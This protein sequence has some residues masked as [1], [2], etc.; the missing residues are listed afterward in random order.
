MIASIE[1]DNNVS[2]LRYSKSTS[3]FLIL[4]RT[5]SF[6]ICDIRSELNASTLVYPFLLSFSFWSCIK[7]FTGSMIIV[8][9]L[10][11]FAR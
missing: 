6:S 3:P 2:G 10:C 1:Y 7:A 5:A 9:L 11:F 4:C 8:S